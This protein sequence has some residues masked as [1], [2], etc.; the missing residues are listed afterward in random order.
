MAARPDLIVDAGSTRATFV[1]L[2][3]RVQGQTGI[4]T[5]CWALNR[6]LAG[7]VAVQSVARPGP[8]LHSGEA[9]PRPRKPPRRG[10]GGRVVRDLD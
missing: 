6:V 10:G 1:E 4:P 8:A 5:R 7:P 2:A 3:D 9:P